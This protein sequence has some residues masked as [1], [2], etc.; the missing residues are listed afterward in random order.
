MEDGYYAYGD[1]YSSGLLDWNGDLRPETLVNGSSGH[2]ENTFRLN[3]YGIPANP[4]V[5][6]PNPNLLPGRDLKRMPHE[7]RTMSLPARTDMM[8]KYNLDRKLIPSIS[9][10]RDDSMS[11]NYYDRPLDYYEGRP[12]YYR[13]EGFLGGATDN[14]TLFLLF[15]FIVFV[16]LGFVIM[17]TVSD[18]RSV[19][20]KL[21]KMAENI[22]DKPLEE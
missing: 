13:K 16:V 9:D 1:Q 6:N 10:L 19:L 2:I 8:A 18:F 22:K 15:I 5:P 14:N 17:K 12:A 3:Q 21:A 4:L 20:K 7:F 11:H